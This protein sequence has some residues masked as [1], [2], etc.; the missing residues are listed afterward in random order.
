MDATRY[1][2]VTSYGTYTITCVNG[3]NYLEVSGDNTQGT[4]LLNGTAV[5]LTQSILNPAGG[6]YRWVKWLISKQANGYY[7]IMN[8]NSGKYIDVPNGTTTAG[9]TLDQYSGN[10]ADGQ[11]W[12]IIGAASGTFKIINK[13]NGLAITDQARLPLGVRVSRH[14]LFDEPSF[15][16]ANVLDCLTRHWIGQKTDEIAGMTCRKRAMKATRKRPAPV[17]IAAFPDGTTTA[18]GKT[19][20]SGSSSA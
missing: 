9:T 7:T 3:G 6:T 15:C 2:N 17:I 20:L 16:L 5:D 10:S 13:A 18:H 14:D 4:K 19:T 11:Y 12:S 1:I 8:L